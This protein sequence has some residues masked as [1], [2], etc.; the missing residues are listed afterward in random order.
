M[1]LKTEGLTKD[2]GS[3]RAVNN[4]SLSIEEGDIQAII[5]PNGAGKSTFLDLITN[6]TRP[7]SGQ[8][9]FKD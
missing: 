7:T 5:G 2:F 9:Y 4:V 6:R 8:V 1:I 3:L